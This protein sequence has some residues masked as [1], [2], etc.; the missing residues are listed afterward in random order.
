M[1]RVL[2]VFA[3]Q[4]VPGRVKTR[5]A[6]VI[7]AGP[8]ARLY[9]AFLQDFL[10]RLHTIRARRVLAYS[11]RD[12]KAYFESLVHGDFQL[13]RQASGDL[14]DRMSQFFRQEFERGAKRVVLVG[15]DTPDLPLPYVERAFSELAKCDVVLGPCDDGGYYLVAKRRMVS[16]MF[17]GIMWGGTAVFR[18]TV[19]RISRTDV[20]L[21][22]LSRW[23][24]VDTV[25][26]LVRLWERI[27]LARRCWSSSSLPNTEAVL[28]TLGQYLSDRYCEL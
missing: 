19:E 23:S 3:K 7:G 15:T 11:E 5:L 4:P 8:A 13:V 1:D 21:A 24:D 27:S 9:R 28:K 18:Q 17:Q 6:T 26:D 22:V 25:G 20:R 16:E 10:P 14:G 2:G 12:E